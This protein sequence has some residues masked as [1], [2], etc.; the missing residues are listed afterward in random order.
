MTTHA[1]GLALAIAY[2]LIPL[3]AGAADPDELMAGQLGKVLAGRNVQFEAQPDGHGKFDL[4]DAV[5]D[6]TVGG[7]TLQVF[8]TGGVA[9][10]DVYQLPADSWRRLPAGNS[11]HLV[12]YIYHGSGTPTDPCT[13]VLVQAKHV[14]A[15][16]KGSAVNLD[17]PFAGEIG[18]VLNLGTG[19][20]RY[21][22]SFGG[23]TI[24]N[25]DNR[26]QRRDAPPP[27]ACPTPGGGGGSTTS[28][29]AVG[30]T[31]S[32]TVVET[33]TTSLG[34]GETTTT[35]LGGGETTTT[36]LGGGETTTTSLGGGTTTTTS[37][38]GGTTTTTSIGGGETTTTSTVVTETTTTTIGGGGCCNGASHV[39]FTTANAP[40]DCGD[41]IDNTG[42]VTQLQ[43]SGLYTGGGGNTVPLPITI[44]DLGQ[45]VS[46]LTACT[47]QTATLG[48][49]TSTDTG[50]NR[51][52]TGVGCLF[53]APLAVPNPSST[54]TSVCVINTVTSAIAGTLVCDTGATN[55]NLPLSSN[56]FLTG[57][58]LTDDGIQPC[59][60]CTGATPVCVGGAS[61]GMGCTPGTTDL[62]EGYP[63]SH[64]CLPVGTTS[65]GSIPIAFA[66]SS[67]TVTWVGTAATNDTEDTSVGNQS[68]VFSGFC[69]DT[70]G[71]SNFKNPF[72]QCWENGAP[73]GAAC[74][75]PF[76]TCEQKNNG[77]FGPGGGLT[78]TITAIGNG[79]S[80]LGGPAPGALVSV[81]TIPPTFNSTVDAAGDLPG[82]GA[83]AIPG[84]AELCTTA[85]PCP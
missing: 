52:C 36:S 81:F 65:I 30:T 79:A 10:A 20:K 69:R 11:P 67:G 12:G 54:P 49:T 3:A 34:G 28:T 6:P 25:G 84:T 23:T 57:D 77:A 45:A 56:I 35:S 7:G 55:A 39:S 26:T 66:L 31:T 59:P 38:G 48:G 74:A 63:T 33:T 32:T 16:C 68:R 78:K 18:I 75:E 43:C 83:V 61:N 24:K 44:P 80:I 73:V 17:P 85:N 5:N 53:G 64:D 19:P 40:G 51:N 14:N 46:A 76:E 1:L 71:T 8:D 29:I 37:I 13:L 21:C 82:P 50:S 47:G 72:Q 62:G 9:G 2:T 15:I 41:I 42:T 22:A 58:I 4:P 70:N 60:L 27:A